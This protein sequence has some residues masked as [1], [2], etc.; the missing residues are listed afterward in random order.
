MTNITGYFRDYSNEPNNEVIR[1]T[2]FVTLD[3]KLNIY[4]LCEIAVG[5]SSSEDVVPCLKCSPYT[6]HFPNKVLDFRVSVCV[7]V[8]VCTRH[9]FHTL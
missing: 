7:C 8:C 2:S 1:V 9:T 6:I 3:E 4:T 5:N